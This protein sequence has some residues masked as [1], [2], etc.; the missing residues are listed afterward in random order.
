M[1]DPDVPPRLGPVV[2][3]TA[4]LF[5]Y[6]TLRFPR[7]LTA[8]LGHVPALTPATVTGWRT[9]ALRNRPYPGLV[10]ADGKNAEGLLLAGLSAREWR[11]LDDF[12]DDQYALR[13]LTLD[14]APPRPAAER[15]PPEA[16]AYVWV[17]PGEVRAHTWEAE[18]FAAH[19]L[20]AYAARLESALG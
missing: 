9:A 11:L 5:V 1:T 17:S 4:A 18:D 12:E 15:L 10:R 20:D 19:Q 14:A 13:T 6:G 8:L 3:G 16:W 7:I 2:P